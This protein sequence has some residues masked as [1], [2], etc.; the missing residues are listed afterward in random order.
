M[1]NQYQQDFRKYVNTVSYSKMVDSGTVV[2]WIVKAFKI[3]RIV[4]TTIIAAVSAKVAQ[5]SYQIDLI[6]GGV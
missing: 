6:Q 2:S 5:L 1:R 3:L 4:L